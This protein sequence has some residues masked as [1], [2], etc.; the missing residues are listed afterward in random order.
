MR[1]PLRKFAYSGSLPA[2][3]RKPAAD[4]L[5]NRRVIAIEAEMGAEFLA[6]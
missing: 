4:W 1:S 6:Y 3:E 2:A 5:V